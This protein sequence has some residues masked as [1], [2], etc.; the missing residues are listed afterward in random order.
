MMDTPAS[1][2]QPASS[3]GPSR[4]CPHC[5]AVLP[6]DAPE[7][8]CPAC[9]LLNLTLEPTVAAS[10]PTQ[11]AEPPQPPAPPLT[12]EELAPY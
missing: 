1:G 10:S 2:G 6:A 5:G 11:P 3:P 12:P 8:Q 7:G 4:T 9:L